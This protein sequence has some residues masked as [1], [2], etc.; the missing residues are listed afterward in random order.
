[1][2][3]G[4]RWLL[5]L[6]VLLG[7]VTDVSFYPPLR[8]SPKGPELLTN[9]EFGNAAEG[10]TGNALQR[11]ATLI[12]G[13]VLLRNHDRGGLALLQELSV[14]PGGRLLISAQVSARGVIPGAKSWNWLA[15][16]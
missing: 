1:M 8:Y 5:G 6:V 13:G 2:R 4:V 10:W 16:I 3:P 9:P 12:E 11:G 14:K 15:S 7:L